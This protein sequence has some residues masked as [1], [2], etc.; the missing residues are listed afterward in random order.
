MILSFKKIL[1]A[2]HVFVTASYLGHYMPLFYVM[3][4]GS[5]I[6]AVHVREL[7]LFDCSLYGIL[8]KVRLGAVHVR[9]ISRIPHDLLLLFKFT[10]CILLNIFEMG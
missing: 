3:R 5:R 2:S 6:G 10:L 1:V 7:P 9:E 8:I 4:H